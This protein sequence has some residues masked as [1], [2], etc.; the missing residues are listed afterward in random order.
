MVAPLV[1][2]VNERSVVPDAPIYFRTPPLSRR[3]PP[4]FE[5]TPKS[6]VTPPLAMVVNASVP[7]LSAT[8]PLMR[9]DPLFK[10]KVPEPSLV[11]FPLLPAL[12]TELTVNF[13]V[14][15]CSK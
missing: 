2:M 12:T 4:P 11:K 8:T 6:Q 10:I 15:Y 3:L 14:P 5:A 7:A 9:F 1:P 13:P